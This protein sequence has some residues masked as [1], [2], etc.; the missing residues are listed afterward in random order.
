MIGYFNKI[1]PIPKPIYKKNR[2]IL[3][4]YKENELEKDES[5]ESFI[6]ANEVGTQL[7]TI[8]NQL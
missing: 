5:Y 7:G 1:Q 2:I 6:N 3:S 4:Q 8:D